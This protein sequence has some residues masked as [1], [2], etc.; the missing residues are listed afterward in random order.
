MK[1]FAYPTCGKPNAT[2]IPP[3][4]QTDFFAFYL[5]YVCLLFDLMLDF[6]STIWL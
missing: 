4:A 1:P 6:N 2:V 3:Y 5:L